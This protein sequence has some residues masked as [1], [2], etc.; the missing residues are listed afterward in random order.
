MKG[1]RR[2]LIGVVKEAAVVIRARVGGRRKG[3]MGT[4]WAR[5]RTFITGRISIAARMAVSAALCYCL[6]RIAQATRRTMRMS[7][8]TEQQKHRSPSKSGNPGSRVSPDSMLPLAVCSCPRAPIALQPRRMKLAIGPRSRY[9]RCTRT[10]RA[11]CLACS[12]VAA[13]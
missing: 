1:A 3:W 13:V 9:M 2:E 6:L 5:E 12:P 4:L 10:Q 7:P 8:T 11:Y